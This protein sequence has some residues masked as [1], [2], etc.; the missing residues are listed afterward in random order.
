MRNDFNI[1]PTRVCPTFFRVSVPATTDHF[2]CSSRLGRLYS[3]V[4][5]AH[6]EVLISRLP[7]FLDSQRS[8]GLAWLAGCFAASGAEG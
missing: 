8:D 1:R 7:L 6:L 5:R 4:R 3:A 2:W